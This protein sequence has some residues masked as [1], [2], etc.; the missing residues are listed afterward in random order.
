M[1]TTILVVDDD[2]VLGGVLG[3]VLARPG[4]V[5]LAAESGE[6]AWTL[7]RLHY[8]KVGLLDLCLPDVYGL[9]L[10]ERFHDEMPE[11]ALILMTAYPLRL[12]QD[13]ARRFVRVLTK[14]PDLAELRR[15][16]NGALALVPAAR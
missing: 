13:Q 9:E 2:Q 6:Q 8:P 11:T 16:V 3:R 1:N 12:R 14:P 10:A 4:C 5:V 15:A 7:A